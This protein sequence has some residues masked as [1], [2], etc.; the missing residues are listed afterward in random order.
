M[1]ADDFARV[2][3]DLNRLIPRTLPDA[4]QRVVLQGVAIMKRQAPRKTGRLSRSVA[5]R[6]EQGGKRGV[7]DTNVA[8]ARYVEEGTRAHEIRARN[9]RALY[10]KGAAHPVRVVRHP[11][12]KANAFIAR[13][14]EQ[15]RPVAEQELSR[16]FG[17]ALGRVG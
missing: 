10:W 14:R 7:I 2:A 8:Y 11:G 4:M 3:A 13:T 16:V 5:G 15:L 1:A 9:A 17:D 12:T 6:V